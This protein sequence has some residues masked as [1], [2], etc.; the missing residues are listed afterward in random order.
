MARAQ[1][2]W[3]DGVGRSVSSEKRHCKK[4][5]CKDGKDQTSGALR[6][7]WE[8]YISLEIQTAKENDLI[9]PQGVRSS[10]KGSPVHAIYL[11]YLKIFQLYFLLCDK[12]I[13]VL[14]FKNGLCI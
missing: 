14:V 12:L 4:Q 11:K 13:L 5:G 8:A 1:E 10:P 2:A 7:Y 3:Q 9:P 6:M